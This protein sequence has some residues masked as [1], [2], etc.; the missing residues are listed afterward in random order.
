MGQI[1]EFQLTQREGADD[2]DRGLGAGVAAGIHQHGNEGGEGHL[3]SQCVFKAGDDHAGEGGGDHQKQKPGDALL[4]QVP[5][6]GAA[7][8]LFRGGHTA[9]DLN[10]LS[11][12]LLHDVHGVV[13]G[14]N[15]HHAVFVVHNGE[16]QKVVFGKHPC[17]LFL[18][19]EGGDGDDMG[20]HNVPD[21]GF[22]VFCQEQ[23]L[24]GHKAQQGPVVRDVAGVDG[25]LVHAGAADAEDALLYGHR[26]PQGDIFCGHDGAC[27]VF[28]VAQKL[29]DGLPGLWVG[30][31]E[32]AAD[33]V[34]GHFLHQIHSVV[35]VQ[36][37]YHFFELPVRETLN[38]QLLGV[39]LHFH[40]GF[41]RLLLGQETKQQ[42]NAVRL[43]PVE[44]QL[45]AAGKAQQQHFQIDH[46]AGI[47]VGHS[48]QFFH[49]LV[50]KEMFL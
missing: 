17:H 25:L 11:R 27:G 39:R 36:L 29:V 8:G 46:H 22:V 40:E 20:L 50:L 49:Y 7:V 44:V 18:V 26:G 38:Q 16:G 47:P 31:G 48:P 10:V 1:T 24:H 2:C 30:L 37:I 35:Q 9:H 3:G 41:C 4:E 19:G 43:Q 33:H 13:E 21:G 23:I 15:A 14:D 32:D 45:A 5:D 28:R 6:G 34:G 12:F 42:R